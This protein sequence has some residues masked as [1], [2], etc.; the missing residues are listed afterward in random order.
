MHLLRRRRCD[1][2]VYRYRH[3]RPRPERLRVLREP[4]RLPRRRRQRARSTTTPRDDEHQPAHGARRRRHVRGAA[5]PDLVRAA[6]GRD[7]RRARA[8]PSTPV[9]PAI[10]A[11]SFVGNVSGNTSVDRRTA[12]RSHFTRQR[13]RR[14]R[15]RDQPRRRRL[16]SRAPRE[17]RPA[18][19]RSR[20][21]RETLTWDGKDNS[22]ADFPVGAN[23]AV[24]AA[25]HAGE[26]HFPLLDAENSTLGG[27]TITLQNPPG[28]MC[29]VRQRSCTTA[30]LRRS[31]LP[32]DRPDRLRRRNAPPPDAP[33]CGIE[34][35]G[36]AVPQR[37]RDRLRQQRGAT[38]L[39]R[40]H[41]RQHE[42]PVHR[43]VRRRQGRSTPGR[44]SRARRRRLRS[45]SS[46]PRT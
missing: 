21:V 41:R 45:T 32:H 28:G 1:G 10:S 11:L 18:R 46:T 31:R 17:P 35:A 20:R 44:T 37:S 27:P 33:L 39:R 19:R 2:F 34:P 4:G 13:R 5:V 6:R 29:S 24:R 42:R 7:A 14:H 30:L 36:C 3:E 9:A 43:F 40:R 38:R 12:A 22:G 25:L 8:F 16:R 26:Y 15:D 23:Y